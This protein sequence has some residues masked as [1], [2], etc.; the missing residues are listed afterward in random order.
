LASFNTVYS[1]GAGEADA[2]GTE[3]RI[4]VA[5]AGGISRADWA[6][7]EG[8]K[9][10]IGWKGKGEA[11]RMDIGVGIGED[12]LLGGLPGRDFIHDRRLFRCGG[13][14]VL[15][16]LVPFLV[17]LLFNDYKGGEIYRAGV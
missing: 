6:G 4:G 11:L 5:G 9:S 2:A 15:R 17:L 13:N 14:G 1:L 7:V 10:S 12:K 8:T 3:A 16:L